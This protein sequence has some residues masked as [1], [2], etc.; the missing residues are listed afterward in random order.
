MPYLEERLLPGGPLVSASDTFFMVCVFY[1]FFSIS[2][3][4]RNFL[5]ISLLVIVVVF[6][7]NFIN[8]YILNFIIFLLLMRAGDIHPNPGPNNKS[9]KALY[10]NIRG[11]K[12]NLQEVALASLKYDLI[13]CSETLVSD[14]RHTSELLIPNFNK[15]ILLRRNAIPRAQGMCVYIR[16]SY[17][18]SRIPKFECGCHEML[19]VKICSRFNN[20]Y[21]FSLYRNP[22]LDSQI[23]DCLLVKMAEI[24]SLDTKAS[25][26]FVGDLNAH[27]TEWLNS[28]SPTNRH[29]RAA[30]DFS[31]LSGCEQLVREP[32]HNSGNC[33]D[34]LL[35][36]APAVV[37][38]RVVPPLGC[39]DHA[40]LA[41]NIQTAFP[42]PDDPISR[43]VFLKSRANWDAIVADIEGIFWPDI[44]RA[45]CPVEALNAVLLSIGERRIPSKIIRSRRRDK[46]WFNEDCRRVQRE[47]QVA[48]GEW[49]RLR[50]RESWEHY[51]RLR[52]QARR[53]YSAAQDDYHDHLKSVLTGTSQPH[54]WWSAVKQSLFGVDSQLPSL[55]CPDGSVCH[56]SKDKADLLASV[57]DG[58]QCGDKLTFP[59]SCFPDIKLSSI[60]F[61]SSELARLLEDL[62]SFGG[63]DPLGFLPILFKKTAAVLSPKLAV[64]FRILIRRG[65]FPVCWR[66][67]NVT[68]IP[69][70]SSPTINPN[71]Y[72]PI[73]ITPV[74]SKIFERLLAKRLTRFI[75]VN[76]LLPPHQFGFRKG[77]STSDALLLLTHSVQASL[78]AGSECRLVSLDFSSAFDRVN[79]DALLFKIRSH[80][81]GGNFFNMLS[82]FLRDRRQRVVVDGCFS[83]FSFVKSGVPQGSVLGPLLFIL[84]TADMWTGIEC[85][86]IAYADDT[87]LYAPIPSPQDRHSVANML[88]RDVMRIMSWC[89]R[90]GMKLNPSKSRSIVISRSRTAFPCHPDIVVGG[91]TIPP[92]STLKLLGVTFDPKFTFETHLRSVAS[93]ISQKV[94]LLRKCRKIYSSDDVVRN[95][96]YSFILPHFEYCYPV[97]LSASESHLMLLDRAFGQIKFLLPDLGLNLRHRRRV[98]SL[99]LLFKILSNVDHPLHCALPAF[100]RSLRATRLSLGLNNRSFSVVRCSTS[101]FQRCFFNATVRLWNALPNDIVDSSSCAVFKSRVNSFLL[102]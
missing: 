42:V 47:K 78:D 62:D 12:A 52:A 49:S 63:C 54:A 89:D 98:G 29:G 31:N 46:A 102:A 53:T 37:S 44:F 55:S 41:F 71:D 61:K 33:L 68:P 85:G 6:S 11:L 65:S 32:T 83:S 92:C 1:N 35:T 69:K 58:K 36:D 64:I 50:S 70:G 93:S 15:P 30:L 91:A 96:F 88:S 80:G 82:D 84:Y 100:S 14:F 43:K 18:A 67:A 40:G 23:Y 26:V 57:F 27:H 81:I 90:W 99:C 73:S 95:C 60:A 16:S 25:F 101:Q 3:V 17:S 45:D 8:F 22:D 20:Y 97:W 24:Q 9:C 59:P 87:T 86:M 74:L 48:Y 7:F 56:R 77:L 2:L 76:K 75:D 19:L 72:R 66:S 28:I 79:H 5:V 39:S 13:F 38:V 10:I 21:I 34:L 94:G 4:S 51:V